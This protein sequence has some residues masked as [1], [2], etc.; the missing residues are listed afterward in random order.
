MQHNEY[1]HKILKCMHKRQ[2]EIQAHYSMVYIYI[3][4]HHVRKY[5]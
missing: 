4:T 3:Y 1:I 5:S 2:D